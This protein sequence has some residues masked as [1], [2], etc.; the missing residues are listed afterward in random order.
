MKK[1]YITPKIVCTQF[2]I[3]CGYAGSGPDPADILTLSLLTQQD[4]DGNYSRNDPFDRPT[5]DY[6]FFGE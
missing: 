4:N 2:V 6:N 3:E 1:Q 5:D